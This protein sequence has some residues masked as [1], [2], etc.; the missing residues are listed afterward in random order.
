M[1]GNAHVGQASGS[2]LLLCELAAFVREAVKE[3]P[4]PDPSGEWLECRVFLHGPPEEQEE[5]IYPFV[6]VRWVEG[7][8]YSE[9]DGKTVLRD[10]VALI[11][12]VYSPRSQAEAG[13]LCAELLDCLRRALW[14]QRLLARRFELVEPLRASIPDSRQQVHHFHMVTLETVWNSVWPPKALEEAGMSQIKGGRTH[15]NAYSMPDFMP[16]M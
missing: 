1:I 8:V 12:G 3:Y 15:A 16:T 14:K 4:F 11:L 10:T 13:L 5:A 7:E 9:E 6:V 2:R